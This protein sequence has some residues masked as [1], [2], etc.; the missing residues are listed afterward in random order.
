MNKIL[1]VLPKYEIRLLIGATILAVAAIVT[2][3]E[4]S[5]LC[6]AL[7]LFIYM[8]SASNSITGR[9]GR[10]ILA[11]VVLY[12]PLVLLGNYAEIRGGNMLAAL[13]TAI[14][15]LTVACAFV[16]RRHGPAVGAKAA[17]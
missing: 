3:G 7:S 15:A 13:E 17:V 14:A 1:N 5:G 9:F 10:V 2:E 8:L 11:L 6:S 12:G 4:L 16:I